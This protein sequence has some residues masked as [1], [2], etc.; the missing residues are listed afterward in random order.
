MHKAIDWQS[1]IYINGFAGKKDTLSP[2]WNK[3][4]AAAIQ[5]MSPQAAG[6]IV[7]GAGNQ[8]TVSSNRSGFGQCKIVPRMLRNVEQGDTSTELF[9]QKTPSPFW[10]C[11]IGVL[12]MVHPEADLAVARA[13]AELGIPYVFSNQASV[14]METCGEA[15]GS[16]PRFF[17]LYWSK[18]RDLVASFVQ[19]AE[20]CGCSGIVLTLDTTLL[21]WRT[22][23]LELAYLPFLEGKGIAQ[24]TS[25]PVFQ[26]MLDEKMQNPGAGPARPPLSLELIKGLISS[27]SR[28]PG[29]GF[30]RK[31]R[32][33]RPMAAVQLFVQTYSNPAI[34]WED[35]SF[36]REH[37]KLPIILKGI[38]HPDDAR[39]A[40]DYGVNG[41]VVSNHGGRQV[42]GSISAIEALPGIVAAVFKQVPVILDSGIRGGADVF[43]A[44][45]LGADAV[46]LGRPYVYGLTLG[47]QQG[48]HQVLR[49]LMSDFEL[50]MRL[51]GCREIGEIKREC[52]AL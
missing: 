33:G 34:T 47:G 42:D 9:G 2:D 27:V 39:K 15:M 31:L 51:A 29:K 20:A 8:D 28:Y 6:Y 43:K 26:K 46:G 17:Q 14:P 10:L 44:L 18:N 36:L 21:G 13:A 52:L 12:E 7:G 35:L 5:K 11:P 16:S 30:V 50:T 38:L 22:M 19:R 49:H 4:E 25:D 45:A 40:L 41:L 37:T 23:D 48:V 1:K 32:S 24:Y 3:L